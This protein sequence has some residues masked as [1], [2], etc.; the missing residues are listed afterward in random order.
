MAYAAFTPPPGRLGP[1]PSKSSPEGVVA[2]SLEQAEC[3]AN[4]GMPWVVQVI[5]AP[6][7]FDINVVVVVPAGWPWLI[8]SE[9]ITVVLEAVVPLD[10]RGTDHAE[11][12]VMTKTGTVTVVRNATVMVA[13]VPVAV[14]AVVT[15]VVGNGAWLP[16]ALYLLGPLLLLFILAS[17]LLLG[18]LLLPRLRLLVFLLLLVLLLLVLLL[19]LLLGIGRRAHSHQPRRAEDSR[20]HHSIEDTDFHATPP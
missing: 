5:A 20:H 10:H 2:K 17:L 1:V 19:L 18:P 7:V 9:P 13:I 15:V 12:V 16:L 3:D 8:E 6:D 4:A 11:R 14:E